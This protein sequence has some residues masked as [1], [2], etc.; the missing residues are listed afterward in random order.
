MSVE[1]KLDQ[2]SLKNLNRQFD[3]LKVGVDRSAYSALIKVLVKIRSEAQLRLKGRGHIVTSRLI[4]SIYVKAKNPENI[5]DNSLI[6]SDNEGQTFN[7]EL[8]SVRVS[9]VEG[10]V[11]T[12][13]EYGEKIEFMDSYIY[14]AMKNVDVTRA[15]A[16]DMKDDVKFGKVLRTGTP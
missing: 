3:K 14:W 11:G 4:N 2:G 9:D 1:I 7:R 5:P 13:V 15:L 8:R 16:D 10:A 6:Y 12:N